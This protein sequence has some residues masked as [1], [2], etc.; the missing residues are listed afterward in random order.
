V[1]LIS[2]VEELITSERGTARMMR[3]RLSQ[4]SST[5]TFDTVAT[6]REFLAD[7]GE[8]MGLRYSAEDLAIAR[9]NDIH[10]WRLVRFSQMVDGAFILGA[11]VVVAIDSA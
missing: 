9:V 11:Q 8:L 4:A 2:Q 1:I 6:A 7:A 3:G 10:P 5:A